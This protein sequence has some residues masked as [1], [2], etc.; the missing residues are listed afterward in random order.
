MLKLY[1]AIVQSHL[2][3]CV[4]IWGNCSKV[5]LSPIIKAQ[6]VAVRLVCNLGFRDHTCSSFKRLKVL[7]FTDIVKFKLQLLM[8]KAWNVKLPVN[9]QRIFM[10]NTRGPQWPSG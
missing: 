4:E 6:K 8:F 5:L 2:S 3:Y 10:V 9:I 7:K 1:C